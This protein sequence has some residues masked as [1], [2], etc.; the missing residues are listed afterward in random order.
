MDLLARD[1]LA[2]AAVSALSTLAARVPS[3]HPRASRRS[4]KLRLAPTQPCLLRQ[5]RL[6]RSVLLAEDDYCDRQAKPSHTPQHQVAQERSVPLPGPRTSSLASYETVNLRGCPAN[7]TVGY[8]L[9]RPC[10]KGSLFLARSPKKP[11]GQDPLVENGHLVNWNGIPI[12]FH[13]L[14][15]WMKVMVPNKLKAL[16]FQY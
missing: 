6:G 2:A 1:A 16:Q 3:E 15:L 14:T 10:T 9:A 4:K 12:Y 13:P 7:S 5:R 8:S 11:Q